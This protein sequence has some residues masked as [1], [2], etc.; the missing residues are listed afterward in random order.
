MQTKIDER[1][2]VLV[3]AYYDGIMT[4]REALY[5]LVDL[6][7]SQCSAPVVC[8]L[9]RWLDGRVDNRQALLLINAALNGI[10]Q[11]HS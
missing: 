2:T 4:S 5:Q 9:N 1:V 6:K 7:A 11:D 8:I 3:N 10:V